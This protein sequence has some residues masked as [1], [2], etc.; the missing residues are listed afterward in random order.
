MAPLVAAAPG[1]EGESTLPASRQW[2]LKVLAQEPA[3][4]GGSVECAHP[5]STSCN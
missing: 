1:P 3:Q 4:S 2:K 5:S